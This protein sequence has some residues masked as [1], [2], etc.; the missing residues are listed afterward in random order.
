[1]NEFTFLF[2]IGDD[3]LP[4]FILQLTYAQ[5]VKRR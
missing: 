3:L 2:D 1:M 5:P 4:N